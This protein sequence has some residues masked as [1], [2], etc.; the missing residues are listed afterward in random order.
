MS[1][2]TDERPQ[3]VVVTNL[4]ISFGNLVGLLL[5]LALAAIPAALILVIIGSLLFAIFTGLLT[6]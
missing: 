6:R 4:D 1:Q 2:P 5:K 3:R